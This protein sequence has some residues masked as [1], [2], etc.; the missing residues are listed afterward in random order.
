M[1]FN[2]PVGNRSLDTQ[3]SN[4][5]NRCKDCGDPTSIFICILSVKLVDIKMF[6]KNVID[7]IE[8]IFAKR[9]AVFVRNVH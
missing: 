6:L 1:G 7:V 5:K 4:Y 9:Y 3:L 2:S 8:I